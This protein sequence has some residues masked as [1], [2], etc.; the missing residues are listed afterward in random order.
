MS[1]D[2]RGA[3]AVVGIVVVAALVVVTLAAMVLG[4]L[5]VDHRRAAAAADLA[6]LAGAAAVQRGADPCAAVRVTAVR[7]GAALHRCA[8]EG[9]E[10][11]VSVRLASPPL[12][13]RIVVLRAVA[14]AGP[15][16]G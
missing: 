14:R 8:V 13:G 15:V 7:N 10:V 4:R 1:R 6:A 16:P 12:L 2:E 5:L 9:H 3:A 11:Q